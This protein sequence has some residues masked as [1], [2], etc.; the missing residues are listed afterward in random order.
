MKGK[1]ETAL[2][3][4][5][6]SGKFKKSILQALG[7]QDF[8]LVEPRGTL[9]VSLGAPALP[10]LCPDIRVSLLPPPPPRAVYAVQR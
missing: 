4:Q 9:W 6:R 7:I 10:L 3:H 5:L 1:T 2:V 8:P